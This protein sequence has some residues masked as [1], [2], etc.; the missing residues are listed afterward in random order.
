M[1]LADFNRL[2]DLDIPTAELGT[3]GGLVL[4]LF[5]ELPREGE[6]FFYKEHNFK[7]LKMK[8]TRILEVEVRRR[9]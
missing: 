4:N 8:G 5:G 3:V 9:S 7:V 6:N 2:L 1:S